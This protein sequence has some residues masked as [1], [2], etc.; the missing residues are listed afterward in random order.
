MTF[1]ILV[2]ALS[3]DTPNIVGGAAGLGILVLAIRVLFQQK[4]GWQEVLA[5]AQT[6]AKAARADAAISREDA[7]FAREDADHARTDAA[8]AR[9]S[10]VECRRRLTELERRL[11]IVEGREPPAIPA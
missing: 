11:A 2:G 6:D 8:Q 7:R 4:D 9:A 1:A 5:A 10:D 3:L